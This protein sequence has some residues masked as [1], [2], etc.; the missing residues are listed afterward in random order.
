VAVLRRVVRDLGLDV[1]VLVAP[2]WRE[3]DG[4]AMSSRNVYLTAE[5]RAAAPVLRRA[6]G[7]VEQQYAAGLRDAATMRSLVGKVVDAEPLAVLEYVSVAEAQGLAELDE[8][9]QDPALV[10]LAARFGRARLIDNVILGAD[11]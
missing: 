4:L 11:G 7:E 9:G 1:E 2:A 10:S 5:E 8:V 3:P 6:L